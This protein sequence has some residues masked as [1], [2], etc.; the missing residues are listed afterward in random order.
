M[1]KIFKIIFDTIFII[2]IIQLS[3]FFILRFLGITEI[4]EV[5]T[6]SMEDG[7]HAGDYIL[8]IRKDDYNVGDV[9]TFKVEDYYVTHRIIKKNKDKVL[10]K[11]DANN[12]ADDEIEI[13]SIVGKVVY[14][15]GLLN[16]SIN[17]KYSIAA[18][19]L[20][21]YI[22]SCIFEKKKEKPQE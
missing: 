4:Y 22:L 2:L 17:Y 19:L 11:G 15:G 20:V 18:F 13:S 6:G 12:I 14:N 9:V 3:L 8:I 1:N 21:L 5:K 10:T 16:F 7:I